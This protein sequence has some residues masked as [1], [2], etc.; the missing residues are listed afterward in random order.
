MK[1]QESKKDLL[2]NKFY[3]QTKEWLGLVYGKNS[4]NKLDSAQKRVHKFDKTT[5]LLIRDMLSKEINIEIS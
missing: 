3:Q 2:R 5:N 4:T 1:L